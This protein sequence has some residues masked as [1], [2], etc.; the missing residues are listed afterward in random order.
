MNAAGRSSVSVLGTGLIGIDLATKIMRSDRLDLRLVAGR[1]AASPGLCQAARLGMPVATRG[2]HSLI[3]AEEPF[4]AVFDATNAFFHAEHAEKLSA[5]DTML[6]DL[7]PSK[8]GHMV[9]PTVNKAEIVWHRDISMV[10]CGG[11]AS[12]PI[13]SAITKAHEIDYI[14]VRDYVLLELRTVGDI[15]DLV[16]E[17]CSAATGETRTCRA[18]SLK[19]GTNDHLEAPHANTTRACRP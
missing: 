4:D 12:I 7:T 5:L 18:M 13:L 9:V 6:I 14:E 2:I 1:D 11:Q 3:E 10:S 15:A 19:R 17:S 8:A 16:E